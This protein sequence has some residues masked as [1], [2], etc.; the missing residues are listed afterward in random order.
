MEGRPVFQFKYSLEVDGIPIINNY[1][2]SEFAKHFYNTFS[3]NSEIK[4]NEYK[5]HCINIAL[6][7][8]YNTDYNKSFTL[9]ELTDVLSSLR[10]I[11]AMGCDIIHNVFHKIIPC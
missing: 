5:N 1:D 6:N 11:D 7:I 2:V 3:I 10:T 4:D 8:N 9:S